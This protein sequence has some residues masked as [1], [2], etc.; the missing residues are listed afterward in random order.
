MALKQKSEAMHEFFSFMMYEEALHILYE[1]KECIPVTK[2]VSLLSDFYKE[3]DDDFY[4]ILVDGTEN[5]GQVRIRVNDDISL[6]INSTLSSR[7]IKYYIR[8]LV[9]EKAHELAGFE[10]KM[11]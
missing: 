1:S 10:L 7:R 3:E 5:I 4:F 9:K 2:N 6:Q 11:A 8:R